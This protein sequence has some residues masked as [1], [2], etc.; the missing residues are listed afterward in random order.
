MGALPLC[1]VIEKDDVVYIEEED[2]AIIVSEQT[3][4]SRDIPESKVS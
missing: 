4:F 3:G 1:W 2:N